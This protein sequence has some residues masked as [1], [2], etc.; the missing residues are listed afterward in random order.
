MLRSSTGSEPTT[1]QKGRDSVCP[2][3][4]VSGP[5][6]SPA[7]RHEQSRRR[8]PPRGNCPDR[9]ARTFRVEKLNRPKHPAKDTLLC[10]DCRRLFSNSKTIGCGARVQQYPPLLMTSCPLDPMCNSASRGSS[11][12]RLRHGPGFILGG[13]KHLRR[14]SSGRR[15]YQ[16]W[17]GCMA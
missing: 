13:A 14:R 3:Q 10:H 16:R 2:A 7:Q 11:P 15:W 4:K 9:R 12:I 1:T 5:H 6:T 17:S 8:T